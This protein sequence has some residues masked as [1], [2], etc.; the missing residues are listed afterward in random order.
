MSNCDGVD[1][2]FSMADCVN[3][4]GY[5]ERAL[6]D[7]KHGLKEKGYWDD[8]GKI[9]HQYQQ[10]GNHFLNGEEKDSDDSGKICRTN[11]ISSERINENRDNK[12]TS[13]ANGGS[14]LGNPSEKENEFVF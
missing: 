11:N 14:I 13:P 6:R 8:N 10:S 2:A 4:T 1:W 5:T 7:A 12:D 9:F 3:K